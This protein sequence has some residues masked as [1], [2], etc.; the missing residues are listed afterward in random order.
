MAFGVPAENKLWVRGPDYC[1][2][3]MLDGIGP[4]RGYGTEGTVLS[5]GYAV[6]NGAKSRGGQG[7]QYGVR[8]QQSD[9]S[10]RHMAPQ[11]PIITMRQPTSALH[12]V[13]RH[14]YFAAPSAEGKWK[15]QL[16]L[17]RKNIAAEQ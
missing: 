16:F 12:G 4:G 8:A 10:A 2:S 5:I 7:S 6:T 1:V 14:L 17:T 13:L 15:F 11:T 3:G 9:N